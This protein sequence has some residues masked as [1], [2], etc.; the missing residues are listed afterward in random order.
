[1]GELKL[2]NAESQLFD[3]EL[4]VYHDEQWHWSQNTKRGELWGY[5]KKGI[6]HCLHAEDSHQLRRQNFNTMNIGHK[7]PTWS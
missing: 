7:L 1:M 6:Y 5:A 2:Q 4:E 3:T